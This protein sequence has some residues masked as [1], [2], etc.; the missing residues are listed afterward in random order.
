M[1][2][3]YPPPLEGSTNSPAQ[4]L[5]QVDPTSNGPVTNWKAG[6]SIEV[7]IGGTATHNGGGCVFGLSY[8]KGQSF[9]LIGKTDKSCPIGNKFPLTIP[10]DAPSCQ[11]CLFAWGWIPVSSGGAEYY[12]QCAKV[13]ISGKAGGILSGP[14]MPF[15]NMP[16]YESHHGDGAADH[17][18]VLELLEKGGYSSA[19]NS[20][21]EKP[22]QEKTSEAP[23]AVEQTKAGGNGKKV[24]DSDLAGGSYD[25]PSSQPISISQQ[26]IEEEPPKDQKAVD[27]SS[28][29]QHIGGSDAVN[30]EEGD[31]SDLQEP[32][33]G[34][35]ASKSDDD[36]E[37]YEE[38]EIC[39]DK[40]ENGSKDY[41][42]DNN[43]QPDLVPKNDNTN[44]QPPN[45]SYANGS[46]QNNKCEGNTYFICNHGKYIPIPCAPGTKC[47][48]D[49]TAGCTVRI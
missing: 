25:N 10:S 8:D 35:E 21:A 20:K 1:L 22:A 49:R 41:S 5:C 28:D 38:V 18:G 3:K 6:E 39:D 30:P 43:T 32:N 40:G 36:C 13:K 44:M 23:I 31:G 45:T 15:A 42:E 29:Y 33:G 19:D 4:R 46:C 14:P 7:D 2:L 9:T 34:E 24:V 27:D 26:I 12:M 37:E 11:D 48:T 47:G 17:V 16:G